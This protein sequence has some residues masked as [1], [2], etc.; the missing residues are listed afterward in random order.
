MKLIRRAT[1]WGNSAGVRVPRK[2]LGLEVEAR[3]L[4][5]LAIEEVQK[6]V[7]SKM[8]PYLADIQGIYLTG[9]YARM[10]QTNT[11]DVDILVIMDKPIKIPKKEPYDIYAISRERMDKLITYYP[12]LIMSMIKEARPIINGALLKDLRKIELKPSYFKEHAESTKR[13]LRI[14]DDLMDGYGDSDIATSSL[15]Y[16]IILRLRGLYLVRAL[17]KNKIYKTLDIKKDIGK[18]GIEKERIEEIYKIYQVKR[19]AK[20]DLRSDITIGEMRKIYNLALKRYKEV[21]KWLKGR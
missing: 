12:L 8:N 10:E 3:P 5:P 19:D 15:I 14:I 13:A 4:A 11:S 7:L 1:E 9:S 17:L 18:E 21:R 6:D 16:P 20:K 2:W